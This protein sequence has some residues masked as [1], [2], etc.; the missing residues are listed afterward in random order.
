[1]ISPLAVLALSTSIWGFALRP[2]TLPAILPPPSIALSIAEVSISEGSTAALDDEVPPRLELE[3]ER[4]A[5]SRTRTSMDW[6]RGLQI[7]THAAMATTVTLGTI[8]FA[9]RYGF[10]DEARE[11][12]CARGTAVL[13]YCGSETPVAYLVAAGATGVFGTSMFVVWTQL[14]LERAVH[15]DGD[16]RVFE[17]T[18]LLA[19]LMNAA[20]AL[21]GVL[22]SNAPELGWADEQEDFEVLQALGVAHTVWGFATLAVETANTVL[23]F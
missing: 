10:H 14:D 18:R 23:V 2:P 20:G 4:E 9:D 16:W 11:T 12:A 13:G 6:I 8:N 3:A 1:M 17:I 22:I 5:M 19:R 15:I 7:A 21:F